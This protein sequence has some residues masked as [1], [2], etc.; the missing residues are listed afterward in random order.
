[1]TYADSDKAILQSH[2]AAVEDWMSL[3]RSDVVNET[4]GAVEFI[5]KE[6]LPEIR[7][8]RWFSIASPVELLSLWK[9]FVDIDDEDRERKESVFDF[10]VNGTSYMQ[11]MS[12]LASAHADSFYAH[13][14]QSLTWTQRAG[15]MPDLIKENS[16]TKENIV[17]M[18]KENPW[19][20]FLILLTLIKPPV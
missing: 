5:F 19:A 3:Y 14:A 13:V 15:V 2:I 9:R 17:K 20:L 1:M 16:T 7:R 18:L 11:L 4:V 8:V 6:Q 12:S 10:Y